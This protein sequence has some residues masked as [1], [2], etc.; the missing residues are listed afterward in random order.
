MPT[1]GPSA[2]EDAEPKKGALKAKTPPSDATSQYPLP[3]GV[4]AMS[5]IGLLSRTEPSPPLKGASP[6][7]KT[8]PS[9][10]TNQ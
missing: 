9:A 2:V 10:A 5:T 6:R 7:A 1:T 4:A 3:E 8:P